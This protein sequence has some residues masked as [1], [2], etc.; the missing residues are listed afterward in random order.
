MNNYN[1]FEIIE[2]KNLVPGDLFA[3]EDNMKIPCDTLLMSGEVLVDEVSLTGESIPIPKE[4]L[5]ENNNIF[6]YN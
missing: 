5:E 6:N 4:P 3:I 2:S 1:E